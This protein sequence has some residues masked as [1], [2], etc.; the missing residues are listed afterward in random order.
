MS[1]GL[2]KVLQC[3]FRPHEHLW[4]ISQ[5]HLQGAND[6]F[7]GASWQSDYTGKTSPSHNYTATLIM[8]FEDDLMNGRGH[9]KPEHVQISI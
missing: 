2:V 6:V 3:I 7:V 5:Q 4:N 9:S 8:A 1:C